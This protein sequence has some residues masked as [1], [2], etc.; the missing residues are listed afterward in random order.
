MRGAGRRCRLI[1]YYPGLFQGKEYYSQ[2]A[3]FI[4]AVFVQKVE[5][6]NTLYFCVDKSITHDVF[7]ACKQ[8]YYLFK[9][10]NTKGEHK[11]EKAF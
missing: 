6:S 10:Q 2:I 5:K 4:N 11:N 1:K 9:I 3:Q 8:E 7:L